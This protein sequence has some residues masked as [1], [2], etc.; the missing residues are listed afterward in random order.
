MGSDKLYI[1]TL[2]GYLIICSAVSGNIESFKKIG[3][4]LT[5]DPIISDGSLY[6]LTADSK[7][8]GFR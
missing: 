8:L 2:N 1:T 4:Q 6:I 5:I 7:I 3:N